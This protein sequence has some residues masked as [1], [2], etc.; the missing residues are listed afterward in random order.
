MVTLESAKL[1]CRGSIPLR[2]SRLGTLQLLARC[3]G[4][5]RVFVTESA[6]LKTTRDGSRDSPPCL[7]KQSFH[8]EVNSSA[9]VT[10]LVYVVDLKSAAERH[11]GST[12]TPG[13]INVYK[14]TLLL[15]LRS[16]AD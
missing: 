13:K 8:R 1:P 7:R 5:E 15:R 16:G 9:R 11:V 6:R 4:I 10:E 12:P 14:T 2:A 3:W